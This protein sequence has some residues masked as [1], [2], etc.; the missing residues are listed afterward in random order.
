MLQYN[1]I[2]GLFGRV[3]FSQIFHPPH[4]AVLSV[5]VCV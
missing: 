1:I 4:F 3:N 5:K 2:I